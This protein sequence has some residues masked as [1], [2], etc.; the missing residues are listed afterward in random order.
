M[1][2]V[3]MEDTGNLDTKIT[4]ETNNVTP[5]KEWRRTS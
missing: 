2:I 3:T 1:K 4:M 5:H